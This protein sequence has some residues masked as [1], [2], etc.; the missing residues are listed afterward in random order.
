MLHCWSAQRASKQLK[1]A[2][3]WRNEWKVDELRRGF[4][5]G[6][7]LVEVR[8]PPRHATRGPAHPRTHAPHAVVLAVLAS[9]W[10][11]RVLP[12]A[13]HVP[14]PRHPRLTVCALQ[15]PGLIAVMQMMSIVPWHG[16]TRDG[17]LLTFTHTGSLDPAM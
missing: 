14:Y 7:K 8:S 4:G 9:S 11:Q 3:A 10:T 6:T 1:A 17:D 12:C 13:C 15:V 2:A 16:E 5:K